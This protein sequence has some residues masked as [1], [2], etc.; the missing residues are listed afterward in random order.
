MS[1]TVAAPFCGMFRV[2][3]VVL[4]KLTPL[5]LALLAKPADEE[6]NHMFAEKS[7]TILSAELIYD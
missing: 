7:C 2:G 4:F 5:S 1:P 3:T 6:R